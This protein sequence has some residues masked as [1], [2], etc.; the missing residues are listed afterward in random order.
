MK[1]EPMNELQT[2]PKPVLTET[3][4]EFPERI[5]DFILWLEEAQ[6]CSAFPNISPMFQQLGAMVYEEIDIENKKVIW[7]KE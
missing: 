3:A 4:Q 1:E 6:D 7:R 2:E 5:A